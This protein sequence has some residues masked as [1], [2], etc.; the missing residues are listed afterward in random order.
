MAY[1]N[2]EIDIPADAVNAEFINKMGQLIRRLSAEVTGRRVPSRSECAFC[3]I[4]SADCPERF[5][6]ADKGQGTTEDF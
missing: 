1:P 3:D 2:H 5:V 4:T 6:D